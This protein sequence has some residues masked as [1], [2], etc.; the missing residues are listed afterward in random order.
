MRFKINKIFLI[1]IPNGRNNCHSRYRILYLDHAFG[2][3]YVAC[4]LH[5]IETECW[6]FWQFFSPWKTCL[7]AF[8]DDWLL[9]VFMQHWTNFYKQ[10]ATSNNIFTE[11]TLATST[12]SRGPDQMWPPASSQ[13]ILISASWFAASRHRLTNFVTHS[14]KT[15][16]S[17][18]WC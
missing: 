9:I 8:V 6:R 15:S 17:A 7:L 16:A 5:T 14:A 13:T 18:K 2:I 10:A 3:M 11:L 12:I 1:Q 4:S